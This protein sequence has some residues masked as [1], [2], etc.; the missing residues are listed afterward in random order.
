MAF[1]LSYSG[2]QAAAIARVRGKYYSIHHA[3]EFNDVAAVQDYLIADPRLVNKP[4]TKDLLH[5]G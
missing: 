2:V 5:N 4:A 1:F 3:V